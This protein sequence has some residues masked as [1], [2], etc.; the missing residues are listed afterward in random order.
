MTTEETLMIENS[1]G[2]YSEEMLK[3]YGN[4]KEQL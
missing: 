2:E 4:Y 3:V 1:Q